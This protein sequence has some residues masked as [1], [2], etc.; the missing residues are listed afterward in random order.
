MEAIGDGPHNLEPRSNDEDDIRELAPC[1]P[2]YLTTS[3]EGHGESIDLTS[4]GPAHKGFSEAQGL[5]SSHAGHKSVTLTTRR[6]IDIRREDC[7][8]A[9]RVALCE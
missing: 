2:N 8:E 5:N 7:L 9:G 3:T 1:T 4:R 6:K